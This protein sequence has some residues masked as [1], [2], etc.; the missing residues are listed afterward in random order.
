MVIYYFHIECMAFL[1]LKTNPPLII[2]PDAPLARSVST[3]FFKSI[4]RRHAK[5]FKGC[6]TMNLCQFTKRGTLNVFGKLGGK[7]TLENFF[8]FI[9]NLL[10]TLF[11]SIVKRHQ[12]RHELSPLFWSDRCFESEI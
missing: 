11:D 9:I 7:I 2:Y 12:R 10:I 1:P 5:K 4:R 3:E 6:S 8:L